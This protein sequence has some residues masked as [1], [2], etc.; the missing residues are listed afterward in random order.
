LASAGRGCV[1]A[2]RRGEF[3]VSAVGGWA[4]AVVD[5]RPG[6]DVAINDVAGSGYTTGLLAYFVHC[7]FLKFLMAAASKGA[8]PVD[9][10]APGTYLFVVPISVFLWFSDLTC[11]KS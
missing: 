5:A 10:T 4:K 7:G 6:S 1:G 11:V 2:G 8:A 9:R 3:A